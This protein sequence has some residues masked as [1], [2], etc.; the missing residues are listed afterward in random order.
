MTAHDPLRDIIGTCAT[1]IGAITTSILSPLIIGGIIV[2]LNVGEIEAGSLITT[3]LLVI[4]ITSILIAPLMV[5]IPHHI[6]AITAALVLVVSLVLSSQ[7]T[8]ISGLYVWRILAGLATGCLIATVNASIA[9]S[10]SPTLL[11]GLA[12]ATAY[13]VTAVLA[14]IITKLLFLTCFKQI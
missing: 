14:V 7:V 11:Y 8:D 10:R 2:G 9:Q 3:E 1:Q 4:G 12:W 13:T 5:R 6:L